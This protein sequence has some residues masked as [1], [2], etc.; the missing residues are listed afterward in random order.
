MSMS[1]QETSANWDRMKTGFRDMLKQYP[2]QWNVNSFAYY[3]CQAQDKPTAKT[4]I[5]AIKDLRMPAWNDN[6][7]G[8]LRC[9]AWAL[10]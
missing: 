10:R 6:D 5:M 9:E 8:Y 2:N 1:M 4:E 7:D 3:A